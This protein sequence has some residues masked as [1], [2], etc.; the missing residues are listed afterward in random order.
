MQLI[1]SMVRPG[2]GNPARGPPR[3]IW[4]QDI[5][6]VLMRRQVVPRASDIR[7]SAAS[8]LEESGMPGWS[9]RARALPPGLIPD[10]RALILNGALA[11][12]E[13]LRP[14]EE[15]LGSALSARGCA[16]ERIRLRD[17][18]IAY[19]KGCFDCWVK[20]PGVCATK[21]GAGPITRAMAR[22]DLIVLLSPITFG[23]YSSELK[24]VLDR[25]IGIV[26]PFFTRLHG[27]VH[28]KPRYAR[29]PALLAIGVTEDRDPAEAQIFARLV[30]RNAINYHAPAH[31][32]AIVSRDDSPGQIRTAIGRAVSQLMVQRGAA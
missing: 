24:K 18:F 1:S 10:M 9:R 29:Y 7:Q 27:E 28:H 30:D 13:G 3:S 20:T 31:V 22:S 15:A 4:L 6:P 2:A 23:G 12:D 26:S 32:A 25:S 21:D 5:R 16:V 14:I 19:C 17:V 8:I 11:G